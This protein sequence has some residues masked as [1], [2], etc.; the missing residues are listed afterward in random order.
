M[1]TTK[2]RYGVVA[3]TV[4]L[5][6]ALV[7]KSLTLL[8][9][10]TLLAKVLLQE[11]SGDFILGRELWLQPQSHLLRQALLNFTLGTTL[12]LQEILLLH[13]ATAR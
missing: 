7:M 12:A 6:Q 1:L 8:M 10:Q 4:E 2:A 5:H 9:A 13:V 3:H 11:R